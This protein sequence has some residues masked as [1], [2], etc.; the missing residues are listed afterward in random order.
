MDSLLEMTISPLSTAAWSSA[1]LN[2]RARVTSTPS[3]VASVSGV[4]GVKPTI[5]V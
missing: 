4:N 3:G 1:R 5:T 2:H